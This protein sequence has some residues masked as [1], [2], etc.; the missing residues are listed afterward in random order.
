MFK[1]SSSK[2]AAKRNK[3]EETNSAGAEASSNTTVLQTYFQHAN[4]G[5]ILQT[6]DELAKSNPDVGRILR[7]YADTLLLGI[8]PNIEGRG[9]SQT[10]IKQKRPRTEGEKIDR[11][12]G[13]RIL[14][15]FYQHYREE[16]HLD[17]LEDEDN[18]RRYILS[19]RLRFKGES[20]TLQGY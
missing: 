7:E 12:Q 9:D 19:S 5:P 6:A 11:S 15:E 8:Y 18:I 14:Q 1:G 20:A 13:V 2:M 3:L 17:Q 10:F 4:S 16:N